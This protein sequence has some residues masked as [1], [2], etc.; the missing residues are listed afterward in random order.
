M[1]ERRLTLSVGGTIQGLESKVERRE[2]E[3]AASLGLAFPHHPTLLPHPT[4]LS[5]PTPTP[6]PFHFPVLDEHPSTSH[7]LPE[8][9]RCEESPLCPC[10]HGGLPCLDAPS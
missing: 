1:E 5:P 3:E 8:T 2:K 7:S 10:C 9:L 4:P 6:T